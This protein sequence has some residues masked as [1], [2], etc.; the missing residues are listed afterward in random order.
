MTDIEQ[1]LQSVKD[2]YVNCP[3]R[4]DAAVNEL[5]DVENEIQDMLHIIE[6]CSLDA[7][8]MTRK[9]KNLKKLRMRRRVLK[10]EIEILEEIVTFVRQPKP[11]KKSINLT[12]AKVRTISDKQSKRAYTMRVR[13]DL[14]ELMK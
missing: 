7:I 13:K 5:R 9:Y 12:I 2:I 8:A 11:N 6:L 10:N 3:T 1:A 14:Q 4:Y